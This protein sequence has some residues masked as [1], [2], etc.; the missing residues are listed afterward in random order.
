MLQKGAKVTKKLQ[1]CK[2]EQKGA[3]NCTNSKHFKKLQN[4]KRL[5]KWQKVAK[6]IKNYV[7]RC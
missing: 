1:T 6:N 2:D 5:K 7:K 4:C 3:N